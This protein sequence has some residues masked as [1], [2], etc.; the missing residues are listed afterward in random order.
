MTKNSSE[1][2]ENIKGKLYSPVIADIM[3]SMGYRNQ[4]MTPELRPVYKGA[5]VVGRASTIKMADIFSEPSK[6]YD[7]LLKLLDELKPGDVVVCCCTGKNKSGVW[8]ELVSTCSTA[9]GARGAII[10]GGCRD[11]DSIMEINFPVFATYL[12]P[13]DSKGRHETIEINCPVNVCGVYVKQGD[14]IFAD[15]DGCVVVPSEIEERVIEESFKKVGG[16]KMVKKLLQEGKSITDVF[17][18]FG[19]L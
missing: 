11:I 2:Y 6:P 15:V 9:R 19:I 3:D 10:E 16:E 13:A 4:I 5:A 8:G 14:L 17:G 1:Y 12:S 7:L 18:E